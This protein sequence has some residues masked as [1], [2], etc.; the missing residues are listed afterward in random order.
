MRF[1]T[2]LFIIWSATVLLP[3]VGIM[4]P[5]QW[6]LHSSFDRVAE[7]GFAGTGKSLA[8]LQSE[9]MSRMRQ[10]GALFMSIPELR[11]LI[12]EN[13]FELAPENL[14][15]L[16][17]RLDSL[18]GLVEVSFICV[19]D[20]HGRLI[21]QNRDSPWPTLSALGQY[22]AGTSQ[23]RAMIRRLFS[24][25]D[26]PARGIKGESGLWVHAG[27]IF[28]VVGLPLMFGAD[29]PGQIPEIDG[30][31]IM[32]VPLSDE[33]AARLGQGHDCHISFMADGQALSSNLPAT[34]RA[35]LAAACR[36]NKW[37]LSVPFNLRLGN[38]TYRSSLEPLADECSGTTVAAMLVQNGTDPAETVRRKVTQ[39]LIV[40][41]LLGLLLSLFVSYVLSG[42]VTRPVR[43]LV[44]G[45]KAVAGGDLSITLGVKRHDELGELAVAFNDMVRG[46]RKQKELQALV[47]ESQ[48]ASRAKSQFLANMSHEIRTPLHGVI[49]MS[50]LLLRT[51][52]SDRQRRFVG[53]VKS[54]AEVLTTLINDILDFSKI[55][56]GKL[57]LEFVEFDLAALIEDVVELL[58][59]KAFGKGLEIAS[60]ISA[61]V[62]TVVRGD[63]TRLRQIL[64]NLIGN[65]IKFTE[66]GTVAVSVGVEREDQ[67]GSHLRVEISDTGMGIP[68]DRVDRLFKS[69]SQVDASTTRRFGGTGLGLAISKQLVEL[70]NGQI[71]VQSEA[72][73]GSTFSFTFC[74]T[75][76]VRPV[77][78]THRLPAVRVLVVEDNDRLSHFLQRQL[79]D[80]GMTVQTA[81]NANDALRI[82][83]ADE[84]GQP[85]ALA[86][87]DN[88]LPDSTGHDL[89]AKIHSQPRLASLALVLLSPGDEETGGNDPAACGFCG[90]I[91]KPVRRMQLLDAIQRALDPKSWPATLPNANLPRIIPVGRSRRILLAEDQEVNQIVASE[92]LTEA[93]YSLDIVADGQAAVE[94][95]QRAAYDLVLMDCQMPRLDGFEASRL[96][97]LHERETA[98][99][100]R[101]VQHVPILALTAN[102][103]DGERDRC[104]EAGMDGYRAKPFTSRQLLDA[105]AALLPS[106][107]G[108]AMEGDE[109]QPPDA[110]R[111]APP[112]AE[113]PAGKDNQPPFD[114]AAVM[115]RCS[116]KPAL[117]FKVL[118]KFQ[119]QA[120]DAIE[121]IRSSVASRDGEALARA[122][123]A[124]KG[125]A[126]LMAA[127][128]LRMAA[129]RWRKS[130]ECAPSIWPTKDWSNFG[131]RLNAARS[132]SWRSPPIP[133]R[134]VWRQSKARCADGY[135]DRR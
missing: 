129:T 72:G 108:D 97:R 81:G 100:G 57:E 53:L 41:M 60:F 5:L 30:A 76:P 39:S 7:A 113:F 52:L 33:M 58:A 134:V 83:S 19:M 105:I 82:L 51:T 21:A 68:A 56:A 89:A 4:L 114:I 99:T 54:S 119:K 20:G 130:D 118:E 87:V 92:L 107:A 102:A 22:I 28:Q 24:A 38:T 96:I 55:E 104:R 93:G 6:T 95:A 90:A 124:I 120:R 48:A 17:E 29:D 111:V 123:H 3:L 125:T 45:A 18:K 10:A 128:P 61:D 74:S 67:G 110:G 94:A 116:G 71:S 62:P 135:T 25:T 15:S 84:G 109:V 37:P 47:T 66:S 77:T 2:K 103:G 49:G 80:A 73:K 86:L 85:F 101:P 13:N 36:H 64:L 70:M 23:P 122:A 8:S 121:A 34:Q 32:A 98:A 112:V 12:A 106:E 44:Q 133:R 117:A 27:R 35:E 132:L 1:R 9:R 75:T 69:F 65:A 31:L 88:Q 131:A 42:A 78:A 11:A 59:Q 14:A 127:D 40:I 91:V 79:I 43:E 115:T 46:L 16:Q 63:P 126:G 26:D 50:E